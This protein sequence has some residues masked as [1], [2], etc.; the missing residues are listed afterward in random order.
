MEMNYFPKS[1]EINVRG[2]YLI[3]S[4]QGRPPEVKIYKISVQREQPLHWYQG[5]RLVWKNHEEASVA[6]AK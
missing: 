5:R 3:K 4:G 6:G 1:L 2:I